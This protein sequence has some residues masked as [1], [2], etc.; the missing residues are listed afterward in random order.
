MADFTGLRSR[1]AEAEALTAV[2]LTIPDPIVAN[3]LG[4]CGA[5]YVVIDAEFGAFTAETLRSCVDSVGQTPAATVVRVASNDETI[6]KQTLELG[7]DGI[8]IPNVKTADDARQAVNLSRYPPDGSR[9]VGGLGR[10]GG[11]GRLFGDYLKSA[12]Q[13][14]AVIVMIESQ[15]G[16][17]N[18]EE[19]AKVDGIDGITVGPFDLAADLGLG[20]EIRSGEMTK[21]Y[22][23]IVDAAVAANVKVGVS[24]PPTGASA[25]RERGAGLFMHFI[26]VKSFAEAAQSSISALNASVKRQ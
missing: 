6:I 5:D 13:G 8:Q 23:Q 4:W 2:A 9:G 25:W 3:I 7:I 15:E 16:V 1:F 11:Y 12:N 21:A 24:G 26:D 20:L 22:G 19:I 10:G 18:I 17:E 14:L